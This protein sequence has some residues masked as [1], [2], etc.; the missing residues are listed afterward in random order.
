MTFTIIVALQGLALDES[1][2]ATIPV[3]PA[4]GVVDGDGDGYGYF[5]SREEAQ[6]EIDALS[7]GELA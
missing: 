6:A 3:S 2:E 1:G 5:A 7:A 4:Y